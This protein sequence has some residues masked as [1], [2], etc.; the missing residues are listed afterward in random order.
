MSAVYEFLQLS[1]I[2]RG[3]HPLTEI[4]KHMAALSHVTKSLNKFVDD[5]LAFWKSRIEV[6]SVS[7]DLPRLMK[8]NYTLLV[9]GYDK[10]EFIFEESYSKLEILRI[11]QLLDELG[12][13]VNRTFRGVR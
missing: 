3:A 2:V 10:F 9:I 6:Q 13:V 11:L 1:S 7:N 4:D 12:K 8:T 5:A